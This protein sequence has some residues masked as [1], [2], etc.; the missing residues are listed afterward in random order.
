MDDLSGSWLNCFPEMCTTLVSL[1]FEN[2]QSE[3][4]FQVLERLVTK[5]TGLK[6]LKLN[7]SVS[8]V[9][10][11]VLLCRAPQLIELGTGSFSQ[12]L[13]SED[14][15]RLQNSFSDCRNLTS[16]SGF[17]EVAPGHLSIIYPVCK[18]LISLNLSYAPVNNTEL[19][20]LASQCQNLRRLWILDSIEDTGLKAFAS[21]CRD[22]RDLR[23]Y[24]T[25]GQG[26][27]VSEEG[28][29]AISEGCPNLTSILYFC[30]QMTNAAVVTMAR[31]CPKLESFRL[32]ILE[33][34]KADHT[35]GQPMDEGFGA[36]VRNCIFLRRLALSGLLTDRVFESIGTFGKKLE[37]LSVAFAGDSDRAMEYVLQGCMNLCKLEIRDSPFGDLALLS[38]TDHYESMRSL[39]MSGCTVT[40]Q[41]CIQLAQ[42]KRRLIVEVIKKSDGERT[43]E[44]VYVYRS[45]AGPRNDKPPFVT[46][47]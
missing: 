24:P 32:C 15:V 16:L 35:T 25:E 42:L 4:D 40:L 46:I 31:N 19:A 13:T 33:P 7:R 8:V 34:L 18:K 44:S 30:G 20:E 14:S 27:G 39:W 2:L 38:G 23:V 26:Q 11:Q 6:T 12:E 29:V 45:T 28:L 9:Q 3:V 10:L 36:I 5:C 47:F 21:T 1:N 43:V 22:L 37:R 17:W 41:G